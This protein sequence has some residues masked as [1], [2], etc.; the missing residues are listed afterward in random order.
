MKLN[1]VLL[2]LVVTALLVSCEP[3]EAINSPGGRVIEITND[4]LLDGRRIQSLIA[5]LRRMDK[6]DS[7]NPIRIEVN[8]TGGMVQQTIELAGVIHDLE[9][10]VH[11][12][13]TRGAQYIS[14]LLVMVGDEGRRTADPAA[15][16]GSASLPIASAE[17][18]IDPLAEKV[19]DELRKQLGKALGDKALEMEVVVNSN[20]SLTAEE[21]IAAGIIDRIEDRTPT[22]Q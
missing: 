20:R 13:S 15:V 21:A 1:P 17:A 11:T 10:P 6:R 16:F 2:F 3:P 4:D 22:Q 7:V 19:R 18:E 8:T 5:E 12:H 9:S 14:G